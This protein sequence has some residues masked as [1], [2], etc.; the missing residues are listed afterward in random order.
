MYKYTLHNHFNYLAELI[1]IN[2]KRRDD[3]INVYG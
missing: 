1:W 3:I 2:I